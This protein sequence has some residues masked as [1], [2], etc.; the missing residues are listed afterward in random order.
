MRPSN[1]RVVALYGAVLLAAV[2]QAVYA[3]ALRIRGAR[4]DFLTA[5]TV[6]CALFCDANVGA[7]L[8]FLAGL[9]IASLT[10]PPKSG[11][12]A[13]TVPAS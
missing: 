3:D 7:C 5:T 11:F 12:A 1:R 6:L 9:L 8:G 4:P 2:A 10:S 13:L